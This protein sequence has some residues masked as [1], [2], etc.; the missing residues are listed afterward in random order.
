ML[1]A[2]LSDQLLTKASCAYP[3]ALPVTKE[4]NSAVETPNVRYYYPS[5]LFYRHRLRVDFKI[6]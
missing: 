1:H 6:L 5:T 2:V 4:A 3:Q